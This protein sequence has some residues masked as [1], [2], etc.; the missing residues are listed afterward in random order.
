MNKQLSSGLTFFYKVIFPVVWIGGFGVGT[1]SLF[2]NNAP[3]KWGFLIALIVGSL[4]ISFT[5][6]KLKSVRVKNEK[7]LI[8][9]Y[10]K[11]IQIPL[12]EISN[13]S[14]NGFINIRPVTIHFKEQT[15]FGQKITFMPFARF[16][17]FSSHPVVKELEE[18][19]NKLK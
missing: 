15:E 17:L 12:T 7:L 1:L 10:I 11:K 18:I 9:N 6:L 3:E 19:M 14:E 5:C 2:W 16:A 4:F 8:S 13:V